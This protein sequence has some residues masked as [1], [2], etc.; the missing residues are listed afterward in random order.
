MTADP[1][2]FRDLAVV[3]LAAVLGAAAAAYVRR[4]HDLERVADAYRTALED[5][6]GGEAVED[7]LLLRLAEAAAD[8]GLAD[9]ARLASLAREAGILW[10]PSRLRAPGPSRF[11]RGRG[12]R[13]SS[14][15]PPPC[16]SRSDTGSS[17]RGS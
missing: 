16:A 1:I 7:A 10:A 9:T 11:R 12:S 17:R 2:F 13:A 5:A 6:A 14:S 15:A 4:E 3:L 8:V